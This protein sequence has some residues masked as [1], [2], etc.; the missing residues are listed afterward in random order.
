MYNT[1]AQQLRDFL[2]TA[3]PQEPTEHDLGYDKGFEDGVEAGKNQAYTSIL[4]IIMP[5]DAE[6]L[7]TLKQLLRA[8]YL[9]GVER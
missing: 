3:K 8:V 2:N 1:D 9:A 5:M 7:A 4:N 6:G